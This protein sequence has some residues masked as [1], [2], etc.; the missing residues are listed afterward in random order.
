[1]LMDNDVDYQTLFL[2]KADLMRPRSTGHESIMNILPGPEAAITVQAVGIHRCT[3]VLRS[4]MKWAPELN[5]EGWVAKKPRSAAA[6]WLGR[7]LQYLDYP[8]AIDSKLQNDIMV[9]LQ[10]T[11]ITHNWLQL[12]VQ[13]GITTIAI[14]T[15]ATGAASGKSELWQITAVEKI[16]KS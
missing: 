15:K 5:A 11:M 6:K 1:M 16:E 2:L 9:K 14:G 13:L 7:S 3:I 8:R 10:S 12:H 4:V